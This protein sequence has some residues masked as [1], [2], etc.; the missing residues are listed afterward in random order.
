VE[1][2]GVLESELAVELGVVVL[3]SELAVELEVISLAPEW[4]FVERNFKKGIVSEE[5]HP[6]NKF[7][8]NCYGYFQYLL[9]NKIFR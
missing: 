9:C 2:E 7:R 6:C 5:F 4:A 8:E 3:E 1:G